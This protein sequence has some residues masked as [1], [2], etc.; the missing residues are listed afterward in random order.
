MA[1]INLLAWDNHRGLSHDIQLLSETLTTLGHQVQVTRLGPHRRDGRWKS[2]LL[3]L[4]MIWQRIRSGNRR[5]YLY[6]INI[7]LEHVRPGYFGLARLNLL[8]PNPEWLSP[9]SQRYLQRFDAILCKTHYAIELFGTRGYRAM[10][11]GFRSH[12]CLDNQITRHPAFL[13]LAGAS[14]MKGTE[15]LLA[16]WQRHPEWPKLVVLQSPKTATVLP[17]PAQNIEH[18]IGYLDDVG[19]IRRLQNAHTF[20]LCLSETEGWGHYIVEAMSC[21]AVVVTCDAPPM[22]ELID[23]SRGVLVGAIYG[24]PF[25]L[26]TLHP[27]DETALEQVIEQLVAMDDV[28]R[29][30][31]GDRARMWFCANDAAFTG[32]LDAVLRQLL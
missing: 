23:A 30:A 18:R 21:R 13:H 10:Y 4:R 12:D 16:L 29:N 22:N 28:T 1:R 17:Q 6:D 20:H 8:V 3:H 9:H 15:R 31:L 26:A 19:E 5:R 25:N 27:F 11:V 7:A 2:R 24:R 32:R 14:R